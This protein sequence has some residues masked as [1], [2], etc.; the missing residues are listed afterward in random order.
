MA[1]EDMD[2]RS[3][4]DNETRSD[5][6]G[7]IGSSSLRPVFL[8]NL[9]NNYTAAEVRMVFETPQQPPNN[10]GLPYDPIPVER[11]DLKRGYCFVF[12]QDVATDEE[13]KR[14]ESFVSIINGM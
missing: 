12:L 13:K 7:L 6:A 14:V 11:V 5:D 9:T 3:P 4:A 8:G 10:E 1:D 2:R